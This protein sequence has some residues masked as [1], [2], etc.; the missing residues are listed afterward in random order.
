[1]LAEISIKKDETGL[2]YVVSCTTPSSYYYLQNF[3]LFTMMA[4]V[5][6]TNL[7]SYDLHG[8][9]DGPKDQIGSIILAHTNLTEIEEAL[10]L[11]WRVGVDPSKINLG[12]GFYGRSFQ[13]SDSSCWQPGCPFKGG[14]S[15]GT[16][17]L[18]LC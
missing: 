3:D 6:F 15:A 4:Y 10:D 1:L 16:V 13:L 2:D 9:W 18:S 14:A 8:T 12:V 11:F 5:D 7:M 17:S